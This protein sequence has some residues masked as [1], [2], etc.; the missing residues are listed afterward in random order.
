MWRLRHNAPICRRDIVGH[1][2]GALHSASDGSA[3][4]EKLI[5][6]H[7]GSWQLTPA[8]EKELNRLELAG[9]RDG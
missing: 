6:K 4:K 2:A 8:G 3:G 7:R 1:L 5:R 9:T